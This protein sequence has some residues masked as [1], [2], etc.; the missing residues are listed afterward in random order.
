MLIMIAPSRPGPSSNM[1]CVGGGGGDTESLGCHC[2]V[3][4]SDVRHLTGEF[5]IKDDV[6]R[7]TSQVE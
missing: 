7:E 6:S 2:L 5:Q 4:R 3:I 1:V